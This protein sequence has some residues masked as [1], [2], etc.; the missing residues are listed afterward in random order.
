MFSTIHWATALWQVR[1]VWG[2]FIADLMRAG[3]DLQTALDSL[4]PA[5]DRRVY[6]PR[7][8][9][10]RVQRSPYTRR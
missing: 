9:T 6:A 10:V 2:F 7:Y 5:W 1:Q 8:A 4:Q 3:R